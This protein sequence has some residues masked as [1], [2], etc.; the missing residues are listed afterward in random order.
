MDEELKPHINLWGTIEDAK[1][2]GEFWVQEDYVI[3]EIRIPTNVKVET[4][5]EGTKVLPPGVIKGLQ[6]G[7]WYRVYEPIPPTALRV[8]RFVKRT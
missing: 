3:L 5:D 8:V 4:M 1:N 2:F 6:F 7:V